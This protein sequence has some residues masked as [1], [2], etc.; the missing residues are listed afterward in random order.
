MIHH[1]NWST[2]VVFI[3]S[4]NP[5]SRPVVIIVFAHVVR[6]SVRPHFSKQKKTMFATGETVGLSERI[7]D[8]TG[9][10]NC[11]FLCLCLSYL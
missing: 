8:D 9:L 1:S 11:R 7:I 4:A 10:V 3:H 6:S 2:Q 5:Q